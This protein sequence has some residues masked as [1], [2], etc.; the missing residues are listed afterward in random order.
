MRPWKWKLTFFLN[1]QELSK[2]WE[3]KQKRI[4][5]A[6]QVYSRLKFILVQFLTSLSY[7]VT[8]IL[9]L[10]YFKFYWWEVNLFPVCP[11]CST[12]YIFV[13]DQGF[14]LHDRLWDYFIELFLYIIFIC[15]N[16]AWLQEIWESAVIT[17]I[18]YNIV[19]LFYFKISCFV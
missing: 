16:A 15:G 17:C 3:R 2:N 12:V 14:E 4:N 11:A 1:W 5:Y 10:L 19:Q 18:W 8:I 9:I 6:P 7:K 13:F